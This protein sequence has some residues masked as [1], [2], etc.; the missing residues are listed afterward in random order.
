MK[1]LII[2][3]DRAISDV[4]KEGLEDEAYAVDVAY[5]GDEGYRS[6]RAGTVDMGRDAESGKQVRQTI[7]HGETLWSGVGI[8]SHRAAHARAFGGRP[9]AM[10]RAQL[11]RRCRSRAISSTSSGSRCHQ[12]VDRIST[13]WKPR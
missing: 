9:A 1:L 8:L 4:L 10:A 13:S 5:D 6:A 12:R 3:D 7:R 2:E 11:Q